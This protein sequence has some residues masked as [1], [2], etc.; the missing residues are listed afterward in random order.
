MRNLMVVL[1]LSLA[2]CSSAP[3]AKQTKQAPAELRDSAQLGLAST[4]EASGKADDAIQTYLAVAHKGN[5]SPFAPV[6]FHQVAAIYASRQDKA[7]ETQILQQAVQLG[8]DQIRTWREAALRTATDRVMSEPP[9]LNP[10][11][12][13]RARSPGQPYEA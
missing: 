3:E 1:F 7:N 4:Q 11:S 12:S 2:A 10:R 5:H 13:Q 9:L 6:A 8:G